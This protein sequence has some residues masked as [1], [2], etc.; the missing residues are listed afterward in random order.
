MGTKAPA[1]VFSPGE[2]IKDEL[3]ARGWAHEDLAEVIGMSLRQV[4]NLIGG[5]SRITAET[6][7]LLAQ[8]FGTSAEVWMNLQTAF[9]LGSAAKKDEAVVKRAAL[10]EKA[11]VRELARRGW[12]TATKDVTVLEEEVC[13]FL[14]I[15]NL[16]ESPTVAMCARKSD[17]YAENNAAVTAWYYRALS[18]AE[19]ASVAKFDAA[20][21]NDGLFRLRELAKD[22]RGVEGV[23]SCCADMGV[24]LVFVRHLPQS[25]VDGAAFWL[26]GDQP[27]V[28]MS[29]R[30]GRLDYFWFT[31]MH[32]LMHIWYGDE[33]TIDCDLQQTEDLPPH[34]LRANKVAAEVLVPA[35]EFASFVAKAGPNFQEREILAFAEA[36]EI[37]PAIVVGQLRHRRYVRWDRF[38]NLIPSVRERLVGDG[39]W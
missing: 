19:E 14:R 24:R 4:Q 39:D 30:Y 13:R 12:I 20:G 23:V 29:L 34:E 26:P 28:A 15:S 7:Q 35:K 2:F 38:T 32:E 10:Y 16:D 27:A 18:L 5:K 33:V 6:A 8:A 17:S 11:P 1:E 3:E 37:H 9:D 21:M 22:E 36:V 31:L 25:K